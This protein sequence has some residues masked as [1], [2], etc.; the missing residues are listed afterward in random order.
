[1]YLDS[2]GKVTVGT[3]LMLPNT[4][5][6]IALPFQ[7]DNRPAVAQEIMVDFRR[8][9]MMAKG[10]A[11]GFYHGAMS[12]VLAAADIDSLLRQR[13]AGVEGQ[14]REAISTYDAFTS[15]AK[16]ALLDMAYNLGIS[17]LI[18]GFPKLLKAIVTG[19][20]KA[21]ADE[22]HRNGPST[23]RNDWT[24]QQLLSLATM[25]QITAAAEAIGTVTEPAIMPIEP[26]SKPKKS[27]RKSSKKKKAAKKTTKT[28]ETT[29]KKPL[30]RAARM[31]TA[32]KSAKKSVKKAAKKAIKKATKKSA[33]KRA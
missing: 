22:C 23:A 29:K 13:V 5:A 24:K 26:P 19:N 20:W 33:T 31:A 2:V 15:P 7:F 18:K 27:A 1:M 28:A 21:A 4:E 9:S 14:L 10:K 17:G 12:V 30:Q 25:P 11:A 6:A 16:L 3:G 8:V 32:K